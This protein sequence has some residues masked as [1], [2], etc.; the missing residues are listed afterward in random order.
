MRMIFPGQY[1]AKKLSDQA[2]LGDAW[3]LT[4]NPRE[5]QVS[6]EFT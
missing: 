2:G 6:R 1:T 3:M 4:Q 5:R